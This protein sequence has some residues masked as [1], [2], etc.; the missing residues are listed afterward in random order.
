[1]VARGIRDGSKVRDTEVNP[2]NFVA[3]RLGLDLVFADDVQ[4]PFV[5]VPDSFHLADI[6]DSNIWPGF[7]LT[8]N[9]IRP[10]FLEISTFGKANPVVFAVVFEAVFFERDRRTWVIV[11]V[12]AILR[13]VCAVVPVSAFGIPTTERFSE[14]FDNSLTRLRIEVGVAFMILQVRF[15]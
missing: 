7:D 13:W 3:G 2:G 9:E 6:F 10:V 12:L 15:E 4:F 11:T 14:F 5:S 1:M 8:E